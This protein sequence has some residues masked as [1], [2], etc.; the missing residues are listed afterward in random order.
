MNAHWTP[1][2]DQLLT[3]LVDEHGQDWNAIVAKMN[4]RTTAEIISR[5]QKCL[6]PELVKGSFLAHEDDLIIKFVQE[7]GETSWSEI[8][9]VIPNR[10]PKQCRERWTNHLDPSITNGHW[11]EGED[12]VIF[13]VH[14]IVGNQWA[15]IA[16]HVPGRTDSSVK[17]RFYSSISKR[18]GRDE[19][20]AKILT[21]S[22]ARRYV[23]TGR[24][25][26]PTRAALARHNTSLSQPSVT[27]PAKPNEFGV[28]DTPFEFE[29][30]D[31]WGF[32]I[33][34]T[35]SPPFGINE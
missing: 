2:Q 15:R 13:K 5:W 9:K 35:S 16:R 4:G 3:Q 22:R 10:T 8:G 20:G 6:S 7:H 23:Q 14:E 29:D 31:G 18:I 26:R 28:F 30:D 12:Y 1:E 25:R 17:N 32:G 21:P 19:L 33:A 11:T 24:K 27:P 34:G